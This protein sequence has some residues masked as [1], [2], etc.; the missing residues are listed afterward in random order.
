MLRN[1]LR[2]LLCFVEK[3]SEHRADLQHSQLGFVLSHCLIFPP[4]EKH[5]MLGSVNLLNPR[6]TYLIRPGATLMLYLHR[7]CC[8]YRCSCWGQSPADNGP[9]DPPADHLAGLVKFASCSPT[10]AIVEL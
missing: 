7:Q 4:R 1:P 10:E 6:I 3:G 5:G 9:A 8:F 2:S